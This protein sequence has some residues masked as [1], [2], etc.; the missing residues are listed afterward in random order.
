MDVVYDMLT[1]VDKI[2]IVTDLPLERIG[3]LDLPS[4]MLD[5]GFHIRTKNLK[6][7]FPDKIEYVLKGIDLDIK[8]GQSVCISGSGGS[9]RRVLTNT[10]A[11]FNNDFEGVLT[12][13]GYSIRDLDLMNLRDM[14]GKNPSQE[15]VFEGSILENITLLKPNAHLT[16]AIWAMET[17]G[18][19]DK[20]N[21]MPEGLDTQMMS[22]G[23]SLSRSMV[24][25][26]IL[27][28]CLAKR[29]S[30]LILNDF[31]NDFLKSERE[32]LIKILADKGQKWTL[33][34]VSNDP[35]IMAGCERVIV[36][37]DGQ[38]QADGPFEQLNKSGDLS[39]IMN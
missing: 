6:Y 22:S 35:V 27:A 1:A 4:S 32:D 9:G 7:R 29:P 39:G 34:V 18:I 26:I 2:S 3:G 19:S 11:G 16:D 15:D 36:M 38:I 12:V 14:I 8:S 13:N 10:I 20:I 30:L 24:N 25:K 5:K 21:A 23:K 33:L 28:R 37:G 31:F 17:I